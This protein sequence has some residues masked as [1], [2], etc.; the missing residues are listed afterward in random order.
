MP[1]DLTLTLAQA[2]IGASHR[3]AG[4]NPPT[5]APEWGP[6]LEQ[7]GFVAGEP[8]RVLSRALLGGEPL[9]VRIGQSTFAL[10]RAEAACIL[11]KGDMA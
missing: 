3:V 11:L 4:L 5:H 6:W 10:R 7:I 1:Q 2:E 9:V 8:V